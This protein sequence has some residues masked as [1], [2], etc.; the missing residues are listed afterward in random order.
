MRTRIA[1]WWTL[2]PFSSTYHLPDS[3]R[4]RE[5]VAF[6]GRVL[7]AGAKSAKYVN[8]PETPLFTKGR[9]LYGLDKSKRALIEA[10]SAIVCEGQLDLISAFEAGIRNVITARH[11]I[12]F[13]TSPTASPL[14]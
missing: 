5:V 14:R 1:R 8:S 13:R 3:Q 11:R 12:H 7:E 6:S 10:N 9:V 4:L 2:P